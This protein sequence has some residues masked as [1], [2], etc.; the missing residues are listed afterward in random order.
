V[1]IKHDTD[2][3]DLTV[4]TDK[5]DQVI[6]ATEHHLFYD[7][8]RHSWVEAA[9]LPKGDRLT[10]NDGSD[11]T[12]VDGVTPANAGGDM[13]DLT[14]P[15]DH[16]FYVEAGDTAVLVHND[17]GPKPG[18]ATCPIILPT[19]PKL[20]AEYSSKTVSFNG[21]LWM[22]SG[23]RFELP[24]GFT[25]PLA[26]DMEQMAQDIGYE[27]MPAEISRPGAKF[28]DNGEEGSYNLWHAEK[29]GSVLSPG[30]PQAVSKAM[31][32]DCIAWHVKLAVYLNKSIYITEP[33]GVFRF[34]PDG[35]WTIL[36]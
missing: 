23:G 24:A 3:Y 13:W 14:V 25:R 17:N 26:S 22:V 1:E 30:T 7:S 12:V 34:D 29:Q 19:L 18:D 6:H 11:V 16:D 33:G 36:P 28:L 32:D 10:T 4:H 8:T 20:P 15:G 2:L 21:K 27:T 31:C 35:G 9:K 5:G